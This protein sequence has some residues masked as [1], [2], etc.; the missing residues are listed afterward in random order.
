MKSRKWEW[1]F[2]LEALDDAT[3]VVFSKVIPSGDFFDNLRCNNGGIPKL[4]KCTKEVA[5]A[6]DAKRI[7][8]GLKFNVY[9]R[10]GNEGPITKCRKF[11]CKD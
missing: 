1:I 10:F 4:W 5:L 7:T 9:R 8:E 2:F 6:F 3:T 11:P